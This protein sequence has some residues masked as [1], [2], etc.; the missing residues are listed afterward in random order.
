MPPK[1]SVSVHAAG[2]HQFNAAVLMIVKF[3]VLPDKLAR[4]RTLSEQAPFAQKFGEKSRPKGKK[5]SGP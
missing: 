2:L 3:A 5:L 4:P 1:M